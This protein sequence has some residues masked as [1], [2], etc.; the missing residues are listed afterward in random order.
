MLTLSGAN[1]FDG[2]LVIAGGTLQ[3]NN[4]IATVL[5]QG[6]VTLT[7]SGTVLDLRGMSPTIGLLASTVTSSTVTNTNSTASTLTLFG[8]GTQTFSGIIKDGAAAIS[9]IKTGV[10]VEIFSGTASNTYTGP[11]TIFGGTLKLDFSQMGTPT[12]LISQNSLSLGG[13]IL[14]IQGK[15]ATATSQTIGQLSALAGPGSI[16]LTPGTGGTVTLTISNFNVTR[17]A[18]AT[19]NFNTSAG[20]PATARVLWSNVGNTNGIIG[21]A[22]TVTDNG[23]TGFATVVSGSVVR[24]SAGTTLTA[25]N[26]I[27]TT[28]GSNF[29]TAPNVDVGYTSGTLTLSSTTHATNTLAI[30]SG[31]GG[32]LNLGGRSLTFNTGAVNTTGALLMTGTGNYSITSGT[33]GAS[34]AE[35]IIHQFGS[36]ALTV[37][38]TLGGGAAS[39]TMDG[40]GI[41]ALTST[42]N[43]NST[44]STTLNGGILQISGSGNL[45][46]G[47]IILNGGTLEVSNG[48]TLGRNVT[49]NGLGGT[50]QV[51]SGLLTMN[52]AVSTGT[53]NLIISGA[54][55]TTLTGTISG[56]GVLTMAGSGNLTLSNATTNTSGLAITSGTVT[57]G[58]AQ[59]TTNHYGLTITGNSTLDL[60][61]NTLS[62]NNTSANSAT[63]GLGT[64]LTNSGTTAR[65][66]TFNG[67]NAFI[68]NFN[69]GQLGGQEISIG[70]NIA[71]QTLNITAGMG[72][73]SLYVGQTTGASTTS[74]NLSGT[75]VLN[76]GS[77]IEARCV[78]PSQISDA[79]AVTIANT[80]TGF[81][82]GSIISSEYATANPVMTSAIYTTANNSLVFAAGNTTGFTLSGGTIDVRTF[83]VSAGAGGIVT[84]GNGLTINGGNL[85]GNNL[86][87]LSGSIALQS[88]NLLLRNAGIAG[89]ANF[90]ISN[91]AGNDGRTIQMVS[92]NTGTFTAATGTNPGKIMI[93]TLV[94][95]GTW[96]CGMLNSGSNYTITA[97]VY[98]GSPFASAL[99]SYT[100]GDNSGFSGIVTGSTAL[101]ATL[102]LGVNSTFFALSGSA[103]SRTYNVGVVG[104]G[105]D[106]V[107]SATGGFVFG[108]ND[109]SAYSTGTINLNRDKS[110]STLTLLSNGAS[111]SNAININ[112][113]Q[114]GTGNLYVAAPNLTLNA[115][116]TF[117]GTG[118]I[119][120]DLNPGNGQIDYILGNGVGNFNG[121]SPTSIFFT[122]NGSITGNN[123]VY[124]DG[125]S[126][127][128]SNLN[129]GIALG[130]TAVVGGTQTWTVHT[131]VSG[132]VAFD[133]AQTNPANW[134]N[135]SVSLTNS[136]NYGTFEAA[137]NSSNPTVGGNY[138]FNSITISY[139]AVTGTGQYGLVNNIQNDGGTAGTKEGLYTGSL[140]LVLS[141]INNSRY[142][143]D[144]NGQ[145][146]YVDRFNNISS[147]T[148]PGLVL[149]NDASSSVSDIRALGTSGD[150]LVSAGFHVLNGATMEI[151]GGNYNILASNRNTSILPA[152][153]AAAPNSSVSSVTGA[154]NLS[155]GY[156]P[157]ANVSFLGS[158]ANSGTNGSLTGYNTNGTLRIIG[159]SMT[160]N[161]YILNPVGT[162]GV[163]D[164]T[165]GG[166]SPVVDITL[167]DVTIRAASTSDSVGASNV[168]QY[169]ALIVGGQTTLNGNLVLADATG[170]AHQATL[171]VGGV[172][173]QGA[174]VYKQ[175]SYTGTNAVATSVAVAGSG[176]TSGTQAVSVA[177]TLGDQVTTGT[178][179]GTAVITN[180]SITSLTL[181]LKSAADLLNQPVTLDLFTTFGTITS[182][183]GGISTGTAG[184]FNPLTGGVGSPIVYT[185]TQTNSSAVLNVTGDFTVGSTNNLAIQ[186]NASVYVGGNVSIAGVGQNQAMLVTGAG[187][188]IDPGSNFTLNGNTGDSTP[189]TVNIV[190]TVGLFHVGDGSGG[191][192]SGN[193]AQVTLTRNLTAAGN[194]DINGST[195]SLNLNG[196]TFTLTNGSMMTVGGVLNVGTVLAQGSISGAVN[197]LSGGKLTGAGAV[198]GSAA[199]YMNTGATIAPGETASG[200]GTLDLSAA[201]VTLSDGVIFSLA[202]TNDA[203][204][205][206]GTNYGKLAMGALDLSALSSI[207][208][209]LQTVGADTSTFDPTTQH[210]WQSVITTT[211]LTG[212]NASQFTVDSSN[213]FTGNLQGG[214]FSIVQNV[215]NLDLL[216]IPEPQ[217]WVMLV[218]GLGLLGFFQRR[219]GNARD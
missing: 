65:A 119:L 152:D 84:N 193:A 110:N 168:S 53:S 160:S 3:A 79:I 96:N 139:P 181:D 149:M 148:A 153:T 82:G 68:L 69:G 209:S 75:S 137:T 197:I 14:S 38:G 128:N 114:T 15:A 140:S 98:G 107:T 109:S 27:P 192:L 64:L 195:S 180:G 150:T 159:G 44:G 111:V 59:T 117:G 190:P 52:N 36:G 74:I 37:S 5:G 207:T 4:A 154:Y 173:P 175:S 204:G 86:A 7:G 40:T 28:S 85:L 6:N 176:Y 201:N 72:G 165:D 210:I 162:V 2:G 67:P 11:T 144:L 130:S 89:T 20:T 179:A 205:T 54:G 200:K 183:S 217:T 91:T 116:V 177:F 22:Y 157:G 51:D 113:S 83:S 178:L 17:S 42:N 167:N 151:V 19:V 105:N 95:S 215:N 41:L 33:L 188:G 87:N 108:I 199:L 100:I 97:D 88:G 163:I 63:F 90:T 191:T 186:S 203:S 185:A 34:G 78:N 10:G 12:D 92:G 135:G 218:G 26:A 214:S 55:N 9:L 169:P 45:S 13:G 126:L 138:K 80:V 136:G 118:G 57:L 21:G 101:P 61:G 184:T 123:T 171:R 146:L 1:T 8:S 60:A 23:G 134:T 18:G 174:I 187:V 50:L 76:L 112:A 143:F 58:A 93:G 158:G 24:Y 156:S 208:L 132:S 43:F 56:I 25:V 103:P 202:I 124:L 216:Y 30:A 198:S 66:G 104:A 70:T 170:A 62:L 46:S 219:R 196:H 213:F 131:I 120:T 189:Q 145:D 47:A 71:S 166:V 35:L 133:N 212:F 32:T 182:I 16:A 122:I 94:D 142:T 211:G 129:S 99:T 194:S 121:A 161:A 155:S 77:L 49:A 172:S 206:A 102:A 48:F 125:E 81:S 39:L 141:D 147:A 73:G 29:T 115:G 106:I 164:T 127:A 31:S